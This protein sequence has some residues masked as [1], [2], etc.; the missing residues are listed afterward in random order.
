MI[1]HWIF[2][3]KDISRLISRSMDQKLPLGIRLGIKFHLMMCD[4]CLRYKKQL[5]LISKSMS[6]IETD[7]QDNYPTAHLPDQAKKEI[8]KALG[9]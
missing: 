6:K 1:N 7:R 5:E 9:F 3:C 8:K 2:N 4:L